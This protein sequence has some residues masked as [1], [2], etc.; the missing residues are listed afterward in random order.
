MNKKIAALAAGAALLMATI[1][2]LAAPANHGPDPDIYAGKEVGNNGFTNVVGDNLPDNEVTGW[3]KYHKEWKGLHTNWHVE[4]LVPETEYQL[5]LHSKCGDETI[6]VCDNP[7]E[8]VDGYWECAN[9]SGEPFLVMAV[10]ESDKHG[11]INYSLIEERLPVG[12]YQDM[13][14]IVTHNESPWESAWTWENT[15]DT[16]TPDCSADYGSDLSAFS[17]WGVEP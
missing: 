16:E 13:Q 14:F 10:V 6:L 3:V 11:R 7:G 4:G 9:W 1:P 8:Y 12:D 17:V 2:V 15:D 5:K